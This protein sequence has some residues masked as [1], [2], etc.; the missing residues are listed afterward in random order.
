MTQATKGKTRKRNIKIASPEELLGQL[1]EITPE[2][3]EKT[4]NRPTLDL[5]GAALTAFESWIATDHVYQGAREEKKIKGETLKEELFKI[6]T[7][8]IWGM[9]SIPTNPFVRSV[10]NGLTDSQAIFQVQNRFIV[11]ISDE[12]KSPQ[13]TILKQ[14]VQIGISKKK[15][16][17][18]VKNE[19]IFTPHLNIPLSDL[20][21]GSTINREWTPPTETTKSAAQKLMNYVVAKDCNQLEPLTDEERKAIF[22]KRRGVRVKEG[23]LQRIFSY[24]ASLSQL[25]ALLKIIKPIHYTSH[26]KFAIN[27]SVREKDDRLKR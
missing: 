20:V 9:K 23:F 25:R 24:V 3:E 11:D 26:G 18:L 6:W 5:D 19:L 12:E 13:D 4:T 7:K 21:Y 1:N 15:A 22:R 8:L 14:L 16:E 2:Q 10:K 27:D 17:N